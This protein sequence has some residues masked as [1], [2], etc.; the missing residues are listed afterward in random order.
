M[1]KFDHEVTKFRVLL[2]LQPSIGQSVVYIYIRI[3]DIVILD[4]PPSQI[5]RFS[6]LMF[7]V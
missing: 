1:A 3:H 5:L 6:R 7:E 4:E 2:S